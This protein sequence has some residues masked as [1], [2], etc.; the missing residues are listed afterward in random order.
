M[1][2]KGLLLWGEG[3]VPR[4]SRQA[5]S[6]C[7]FD[8]N[9]P[10]IK[11]GGISTTSF[12]SER[13]CCCDTSYTSSSHTYWGAITPTTYH[14]PLVCGCCSSRRGSGRRYHLGLGSFLSPDWRPSRKQLRGVDAAHGNGHADP[15]SRDRMS[16][17]LQ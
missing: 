15:A 4:L 5:T 9:R 6:P 10:T 14:L 16:G 13:R 11:Q 1:L 8:T 12:F 17:H 2:S 7:R 3:S